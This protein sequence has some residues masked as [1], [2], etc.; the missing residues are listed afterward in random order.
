MVWFSE[1]LRA[2]L[3]RISMQ[4]HQELSRYLGEIEWL[5]RALLECSDALQHAISLLNGAPNSISKVRVHTGDELEAQS[6]LTSLS[7]ASADSSSS[8]I[9][10][11]LV[12]AVSKFNAENIANICKPH[13]PRPPILME[14]PQS[15][16]LPS[17]SLQPNVGAR[18]SI[19][20][21]FVGYCNPVSRNSHSSTIATSSSYP[22][23]V[24]QP[25]V[26]YDFNQFAVDRQHP[27]ATY[28]NQCAPVVGASR[29]RSFDTNQPMVGPM[30]YY[31]PRGPLGF[32][33]GG[34]GPMG[35][36]GTYGALTPTAPFG[37]P[38]SNHSMPA[39]PRNASHVSGHGQLKRN[40][41]SVAG[42]APEH[43]G[44]PKQPNRTGDS[45]YE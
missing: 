6:A 10:A 9:P 38:Q 1:E 33:G 18:S 45:I 28:T 36:V 13:P 17:N 37:I 39:G 31:M 3:V 16:Y 25:G 4:H 42:P 34:S 2:T 20:G 14:L 23:C 12:E 40:F 7:R 32:I 22:V 30:S 8:V 24:P 11:R 41:N 43:R 29:A 19:Q 21:E 44:S 5:K 26:N 27:S 35:G 15:V